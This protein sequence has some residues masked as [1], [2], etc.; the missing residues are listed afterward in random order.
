M[1]TL[2]TS[3]IAVVLA[4]VSFT[5]AAQTATP[6]VD[7]RQVNQQGRIA[8]GAASGQLTP[9]ETQRLE[10]QQARINRAENRAKADGKVTPHERRMLKHKQ[11]RAS[12]NIHRLKHNKR[13]AVQQ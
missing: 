7:Q 8:Q 11:N 6:G 12:R 9:V 13:K 4:L 1:L 10:K 5:A 2:K 3:L